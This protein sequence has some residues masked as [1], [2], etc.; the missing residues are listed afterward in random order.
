MQPRL[1][2]IQRSYLSLLGAVIHELTLFL[3]FLIYTVILLN[4]YSVMTMKIVLNILL[5]SRNVFTQLK[6]T[7]RFK[8]CLLCKI[9]SD[10]TKMLTFQICLCQFKSEAHCWTEEKGRETSFNKGKKARAIQERL[11]FTQVHIAALSLLHSPLTPTCPQLRKLRLL[12]VG[13][14]YLPLS[15][16]T[17]TQ[18]HT[19]P[20]AAPP[21]LFLL[22]WTLTSSM[23]GTTHFVGSWCLWPFQPSFPRAL[24][25]NLH[26]QQGIACWVFLLNYYTY[27][28]LLRMLSAVEKR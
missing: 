28:M 15:D 3:I 7:N 22:A 13:L 17:N 1:A 16:I 6:R 26:P 4:L 5:P 27:L 18:V 20:Q 24:E 9:K 12:Y 11:A 21:L 14:I 23:V 8:Q 25:R 10:D 19:H 2:S